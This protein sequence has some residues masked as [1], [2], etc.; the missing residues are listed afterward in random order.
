MATTS[1]TS[2]YPEVVKACQAQKIPLEQAFAKV[3]HNPDGTVNASYPVVKLADEAI[4]VDPSGK[5]IVDDHSVAS[6]KM[7]AKVHGD[8]VAAKS[9]AKFGAAGTEQAAA[10][11]EDAAAGKAAAAA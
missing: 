6:A 1:V 10:G 9:L 11:H 7:F 4:S 8:D 5:V 2:K 3:A